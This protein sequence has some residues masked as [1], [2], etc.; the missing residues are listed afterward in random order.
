MTASKTVAI[1]LT[2][3][4][5]NVVDSLTLG[6]QSCLLLIPAERVRVSCHERLHF[7]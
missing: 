3:V 7:L 6:V 5:S 1:R 4:P 2:L